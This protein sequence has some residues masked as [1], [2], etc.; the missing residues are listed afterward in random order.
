MA[1]GGDTA[2]D[3]VPALLALERGLIDQAQLVAA[4][5][6]WRSSPR[7]PMTEIL[8]AEGVIDRSECARLE[9]IAAAQGDRGASDPGLSLT[10]AYGGSS[11]DSDRLQSGPGPDHGAG[12]Q[13]S[14]GPRYRILRSHAR[15]G[16]GEVFLALDAELNRQVALKELQAYH[17]HDPDSQS[18]F[19][20][21]AELTGRLEHPG[22]VPVY[23]LGRHPDGR[24][25]YAMRFI[26]GE[27]L[28]AAIERFHGSGREDHE[29]RE[30]QMAFQRLLGSLIAACNAVAYA[31][32]RGVVH[33]DLKPENIMLGRFG[34]TLVV[35]WGVAKAV[36]D[37]QRHEADRAASRP[38]GED[39]SLTRPGAAVGTPRYMSPEQAL[40]N[41]DQVG[42]ASDVY[43][44]GATLY[45]L[46][47]GHSPFPDGDVAE[48][49]DRVQRGIFPAPRR[50]R[51]TIDPVLEAICLK[52]MAP[53]PED[54]HAT[55]LALAE[56]IEAWLADVRF[57]G[58]HVEAANQ[59]KG[60]L[61]RLCIERAHNL[62]D[63]GKH[64]EGMLWLARALENVPADA[65]DFER[66]VRAS[67]GSWHA[68]SNLIERTLHHG[69]EVRAV[70]FS[71]DGHRLAS[72]CDDGTAQ[73]WDVASAAKLGSPLR[74][75]GPVT[76]V[77]F[78]PDGK[79]VATSGRDGMV[80]LW[81]ALTGKPLGQPIDHGAPV[82]SVRFGA[83]GSSIATASRSAAPCLWSAATGRPILQPAGHAAAIAAFAFRP[84]G[85]ELATAYGDGRVCFWR[86]STG[87]PDGQPLPHQA[88]VRAL[89][90]HPDGKRLL[91][92]GSDSRAR[93][94]DV[95]TR[96][97]VLELALPACVTLVDF[98]PSGIV[99]ATACED[100]TARLWDPE[101]G[102]PIGEPLTHGSEITCLAFGPDGTTLATGSR[103]RTVRLWDTATAL[104]IGP[105]LEH[106]GSVHAICFRPD[107]RR[108]ATGSSDGMARYWK[109]APQIPGD[110]ERICCWV[111]VTTDLDFDAGDAIRK[112]DPL[113]GWELRRRLHE[114]G[115]PP[116]KK[117]ERW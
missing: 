86:T 21:E 74:H 90:Y 114:L 94:W 26:E 92:G 53:R 37:P 34:E 61:A 39:S 60:S 106:R 55:P 45:C 52:A 62:L 35:D 115:G 5:R 70:G 81:D 91:T 14:Q 79:K 100:G 42:P 29:P 98:S 28:K 101:R 46:L 48:V 107:G 69:G 78:S 56:E 47:V 2:R 38:A 89:V 64:G 1:S 20:L 59:V 8:I 3:L 23:G 105:P 68:R 66:V 6:S 73:L 25:Y 104:P 41:L 19:V 99:A 67:L 44:L 77:A 18:R 33:R 80:R 71:P 82:T 72:A 12:N 93:I 27:T 54:R 58:E 32:S 76:A 57:R 103:D 112:L 30:R 75:D 4:F 63:R 24:P 113:V 108:L 51:R 88:A 49:L 95:E 13:Q 50:L 85:R 110:V 116:P 87:D 83:D 10:V 15:G 97:L 9:A 16:L 17:A 31:H 65:P 22:I 36:S 43:G 96:A 102:H 84:D 117:I 11:D 40:G 7:R 109:V 111:R